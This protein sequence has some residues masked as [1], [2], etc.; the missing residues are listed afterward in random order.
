[1]AIVNFKLHS[2][3]APKAV[4]AALTDFGPSRAEVWPNVDTAHF[5]VHD[6]GPGWADVTEGSSVA[7]GVWERERYTWDVASGTV[8]IETLE[9]NT[10]GPGSRW[11]YRLTSASGGGSTIEVTVTRNG[12]GWTGRLIGVGL[13][14]A[15]ARMLG[16][17][18][19]QA[20]NRI[21]R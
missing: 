14:V 2:T 17:Q 11:D 16:S 18:M 20:L 5:K 15:G 3:L 7:G 12:K 1:M 9:S 8:A 6:Q 4:M 13:S 21:S 19:K 10:W